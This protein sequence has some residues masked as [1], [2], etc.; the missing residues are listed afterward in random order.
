MTAAELT[1]LAG[2]KRAPCVVPSSFKSCVFGIERAIDLVH[3]LV[4]ATRAVICDADSAGPSAVGVLLRVD[5]YAARARSVL[6]L[7]HAVLR[8]APAEW[9]RLPSSTSIWRGELGFKANQF[10][11]S[12][13]DF[14]RGA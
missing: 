2:R 10:A 12:A 5:A 6:N 13:L 9:G 8:F 1:V 7:S 14:V 11:Q 4:N 3:A